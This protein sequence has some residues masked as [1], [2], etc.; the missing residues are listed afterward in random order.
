MTPEDRAELEQHSQILAGEIVNMIVIV[1]LNDGLIKFKELKD[2]GDH[3]LRLQVGD[4]GFI[5]IHVDVS[6]EET[7]EKANTP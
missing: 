3:T 1:L 2:D 4:L 6:F 7:D 5:K